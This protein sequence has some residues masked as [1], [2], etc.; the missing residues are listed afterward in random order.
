M[1]CGILIIAIIVCV[2][3][4]DELPQIISWSFKNYSIARASPTP[5]RSFGPLGSFGITPTNIRDWSSLSTEC[6]DAPP[7]LDLKGLW[8]LPRQNDSPFS[9]PHSTKFGLIQPTPTTP[10]TNW[11]IWG[12]TT[13]TMA[14]PSSCVAYDPSDTID[15]WN[16]ECELNNAL[17]KTHEAASCECPTGKEKPSTRSQQFRMPPCRCGSWETHCHFKEWS[18]KNLNY[19]YY[20]DDDDDDD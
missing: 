14:N 17:K 4:N 13:P 9:T 16:V 2:Y 15:M 3:A 1:I 6:Y 10:D 11:G 5:S 20:D 19:H 18:C 7:N 12:P 8:W